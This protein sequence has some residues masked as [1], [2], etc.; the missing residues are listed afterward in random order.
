MLTWEVVIVEVNGWWKIS[1]LELRYPRG[2]GGVGTQISHACQNYC[3]VRSDRHHAA[4]RRQ[5][6]HGL[7]HLARS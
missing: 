4:A 5:N 3:C 6:A 7:A 1:S 2:E